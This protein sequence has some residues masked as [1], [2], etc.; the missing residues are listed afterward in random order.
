MDLWGRPPSLSGLEWDLSN[1]VIP[2]SSSY[3]SG[4]SSRCTGRAREIPARL[5]ATE[6][7]IQSDLSE[8]AMTAVGQT[9]KAAVGPL[10]TQDIG[11]PRGLKDHQSREATTP[12][13]R[14]LFLL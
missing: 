7:D 11:G 1:H 10:R 13:R 3:R 5:N 2:V 9:A 4:L 6:V 14:T 12:Q 8:T